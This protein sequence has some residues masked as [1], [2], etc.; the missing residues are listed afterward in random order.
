MKSRNRSIKFS[1]KSHATKGIISTIF[2]GFS[3]ILMLVLVAISYSTNGAAGI[4]AGS[5]GLT[6]LVIAVMGLYLGLSSFKERE[7]Y[8]LFSKI[9]SLLNA[10]I[11]ALWI[12]IYIIG[13]WYL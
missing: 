3:L 2:G 6:A 9:G 13:T 11:I 4:Y 7:R 5:I 12:A 10:L 1:N 8:Y